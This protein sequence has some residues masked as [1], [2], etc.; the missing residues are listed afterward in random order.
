MR[1]SRRHVAF[2]AI[3]DRGTHRGGSVVRD[4]E[5]QP[6]YTLRVLESKTELN[7]AWVT[8]VETLISRRLG[9]LMKSKK[10]KQIGF[11]P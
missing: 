11:E 2:A 1:R 9:S 7:L 3:T 8:S 6:A 4:L 10:M 5:G